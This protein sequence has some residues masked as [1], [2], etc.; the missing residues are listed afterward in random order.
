MATL[1]GTLEHRQIIREGGNPEGRGALCFAYRATSYSEP[2][3][4]TLLWLLAYGRPEDF[5]DLIGKKATCTETE[6]SHYVGCGMYR[7]FDGVAGNRKADL[8]EEEALK[9]P[10]RGKNYGW[11]WSCGQWEKSL[12]SN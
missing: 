8:V 11:K 7:R 2:K 4:I 6:V 1:E 3:M 9:P 10:R 12:R 5:E